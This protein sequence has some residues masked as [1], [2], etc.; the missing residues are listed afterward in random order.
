VQQL[1]CTT[2]RVTEQVTPC[3]KSRRTLCLPMISSVVCLRTLPVQVDAP[4]AAA[5]AAADAPAAQQQTDESSSA[6]A[7]SPTET[8]QLKVQVLRS[9]DQVSSCTCYI[10]GACNLAF[11]I[12]TLSSA[13]SSFGALILRLLQHASPGDH[14]TLCCSRNWMLLSCDICR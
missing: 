12:A 9:I 4:P 8:L 5:A 3:L 10:S 2:T 1:Q 6:Q 13:S 14:P 7:A 11:Y